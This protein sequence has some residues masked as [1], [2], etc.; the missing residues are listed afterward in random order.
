MFQNKAQ[1]KRRQ[2][3]IKKDFQFRFILKFCLLVLVG[4]VISTGLLFYLSSGTLTSS[5]HNSR[6]VVSETSF[7]ILP[8]VLYTNL[9]T[10]GLIVLATIGATLFV[11]HK[12]AGPLYRFELEMKDIGE[13]DLTKSIKLRQKDQISEMAK[14]LNKMV[15][16]LREKVLAI[17]SD[18]NTTI[19]TASNQEV[20]ENLIGELTH[21]NRKI[22]SSFK[23]G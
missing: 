14:S 10:L 17:Q 2:Y 22:G 11:S 18:L 12:I 16:G 8:A 6:L 1:K 13:G 15:A 3:F 20:P 19:Q 4:G 5:F 7:A 9:I 23:V 21:L